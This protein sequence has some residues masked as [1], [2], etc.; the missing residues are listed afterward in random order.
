[1]SVTKAQTA[2]VAQA[3]ADAIGTVEGLRVTWYI[4]DNSRPPCAVIAQPTIDYADPEVPFCQASWEFPVVIVVNR[5]QDAAAQRELSRFVS[6]V[7]NA[8]NEAQPDG[9]FSIEPLT[10]RP[11]TVSL[12]GL[13]VPAYELRVRVRA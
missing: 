4:A 3:L 13:D 10:A 7:A 2:D 5:S 11:T 6:E 1:V 12:A 8:L 9:I